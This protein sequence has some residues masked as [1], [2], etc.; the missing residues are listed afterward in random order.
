VCH[1]TALTP[2]HSATGL[3]A[4]SHKHKI[5][6]HPLFSPRQ[7]LSQYPASTPRSPGSR[8]AQTPR[9]SH[10]ASCRSPQPAS[11]TSPGRRRGGRGNPLSALSAP[12]LAAANSTGPR[13]HPL[14]C[15]TGGPSCRESLQMTGRFL[16]RIPAKLGASPKPKGVALRMSFQPL[17]IISVSGLTNGFVDASP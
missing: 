12:R 7:K 5:L 3:P 8:Q 10:Q 4:Q 17:G 13:Q 14:P 1:A 15:P 2:L 11:P 6:S 9:G 16:R